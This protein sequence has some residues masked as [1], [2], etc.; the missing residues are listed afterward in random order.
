MKKTLLAIVS[1]VSGCFFVY[2]QSNVGLGSGVPAGGGINSA[3]FSP[4]VSLIGEVQ[5]LLNRALPLLVSLSVLGF[6]WFMLRFI[7]VGLDKPEERKKARDGVM[8]SLLSIFVMVALWGIIVFIANA[9][10]VSVGGE[11]Q[12]F[13]LP[14]T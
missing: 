7:W 9:V 8:W 12:E 3:A 11:M 13:R 1:I 14:G 5:K 4:L 2:A 6:F 10:G